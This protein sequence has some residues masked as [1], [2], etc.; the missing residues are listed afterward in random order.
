MDKTFKQ[1]LE[2]LPIK[3]IEHPVG[4]T[5]YYAAVHVKSLIAQAD[6]EFQELKEQHGNQAESILLMLDE[7]KSLKSQLQ[8]QALPVVP[9]YVAE[10]IE[11]NKDRRTIY[12]VFDKISKNRKTYPKLYEWVFEDENSQ[13]TFALAFITGKYQVEKPQL[14][15]L[16]NKLTRKYLRKS[17]HTKDDWNEDFDRVETVNNKTK[18]TQAEIDSMETGSYEQIEVAE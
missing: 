3:N 14:F 12:G 2:I 9:E 4:N 16:K 18:F 13:A 7:I 15:Y 11:S 5:K 17:K 10:F 6:E 1:R 8:Q